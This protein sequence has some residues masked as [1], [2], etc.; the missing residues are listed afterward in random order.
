MFDIS[1]GLSV[2]AQTKPNTSGIYF[3]SRKCSFGLSDFLALPDFTVIEH[4][5]ARSQSDIPTIMV[6]VPG[7][8]DI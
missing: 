5:I 2:V 7:A 1:L 4:S 6:A 3:L 8:P